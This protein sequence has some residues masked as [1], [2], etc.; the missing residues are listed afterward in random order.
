M[1]LD[2]SRNAAQVHY[3]VH[4]LLDET[5]IV[6]L[7]VLLGA[8]DTSVKSN[9]RNSVEL[10]LDE[11]VAFMNTWYNYLSRLAK[12][13]YFETRLHYD[14]HVIHE[15]WQGEVRLIDNMNSRPIYAADWN[16]AQHDHLRG[17][18]QALRRRVDFFVTLSTQLHNL[19][20]KYDTTSLEIQRLFR[21]FAPTYNYV[22]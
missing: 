18:E 12:Q 10:L 16:M 3:Q 13:S 8:L 6:R 21:T 14:I 20:R 17:E 7:N 5:T 11:L 2:Q 1:L 9:Q 15:F 22:S 19:C 4:Q